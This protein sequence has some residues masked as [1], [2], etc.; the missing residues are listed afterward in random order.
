[1]QRK[2]PLKKPDAALLAAGFD[3]QSPP[4]AAVALLRTIR[5]KR[6]TTD[7]AIVAAL[8]EIWTPEAAAMLAEMESSATGHDRREIRRALYRLRQHGI[9]APVAEPKSRSAPPIEV[10]SSLSAL[11]SPMDSEG[12][13][14]AWIIKERPRG[15]I[16]RLWGLASDADGLVGVTLTNFSRR[17]LRAERQE[18]ERRASVRLIDADWQLADFILCEAYRITSESRRG[19]VGNFLT[20]RSEIIS[21]APRHDFAHPIYFEFAGELAEDPNPELLKEPEIAAIGFQP[22]AIKA[23]A[24]EIGDLRNSPLV[25]D[26]IQ[27][28]DR[29]GRVIERAIDGLLTGAGAVQTRR[30]FEHA[31]YYLGRSGR[32]PAAGWAA[33]AAARIRDGD[34]KRI[35]F[36]QAF[37]RSRLG[38]LIAQEQS[39]AREEPHL[40]VTPAEAIR[41]AQQRRR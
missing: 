9:Q 40:I 35:P 18:L 3:P 29:L 1:M 16:A 38:E 32:R 6:S 12:A 2:S 34:L 31:A 30:R 26:P 8:A 23:Y 14:I 20:L 5:G 36:F 22:K 21:T 13:C 19:Q 17:E 41:A 27:Q 24:D 28:E 25:L 37:I 4:A 39:R 10:G 15:G 33:A 11:L 7:D